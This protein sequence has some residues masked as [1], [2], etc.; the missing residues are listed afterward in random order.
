MHFEP[1]NLKWLLI[2]LLA[3]VPSVLGAIVPASLSEQVKK[4]TATAP[5]SK[6]VE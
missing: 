1:V 2:L 4:E 6:D 3:L 5:C